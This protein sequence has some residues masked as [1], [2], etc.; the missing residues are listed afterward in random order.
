MQ[1]TIEDLN[2]M[3]EHTR[4]AYEEYRKIEE[5]YDV[6][7]HDLIVGIHDLNTYIRLADLANAVPESF[8]IDE[9]YVMYTFTY[10]GVKF[11]HSEAK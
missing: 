11:M 3:V 8:S 10:Q 1:V 6:D 9:D 4:A 2:F 5:K 7:E